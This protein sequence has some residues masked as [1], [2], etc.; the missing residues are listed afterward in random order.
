M[1]PF[2]LLAPLIG[3]AIDRFRFGHRW[4]AV[5]L[6]VLRA[7]CAAALAFALLDLALYF[8]ALALLVSAKAS[9][10]VRQA[11][12]PAL[13]DEPDQLVGANS[14]LARLTVIAGGVGG[15]VGAARAGR[16]RIAGRHARP[17]LRH[18]RLAPRSPR[19][20]SPRSTRPTSSIASVE[21]EELH[22]PTIVNTAW[23]FTLVRAVVGFFVFGLAF[24]LRRESEPAWMYGAAVAAYGVG[25]FGG[26]AIAPVLRR[27][28]GEDRLTAGS[29]V[30][31]AIVAAFGALGASRP[32]VLLVSVVL[33]GAASVGRQGFD[34][35]VQTRAPGA[36]HGRAFARFETRFQLGWVAGAIAAVAV[37]IPTR[38]SLAIVAVALIPA[39]VLYVRAL[40]EAHEAHVED[41][42]DP[43]EVARRR[44]EHALEWHRRD[45]HRLA[46]T[47][48][49]GVVDLARAIGRRA[50][51]AVDRP[52]RRA[53]G[54]RPCRRGRSTPARSTG[55][56]SGP[57]P[58]SSCSSAGDADGSGV[59]GRRR[60]VP[61]SHRCRRRRSTTPVADPQAS[62]D[63]TT[64][65]DVDRPLRR[66]PADR[67]HHAWTSR[68][69]SGRPRRR[70]RRRRRRPARGPARRRR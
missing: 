24:A 8:F 38:F 2:A 27:R 18:V 10:V 53:A 12:V 45:L 42:F 13:V 56:W 21:Y 25:T 11:L 68:P 14:R 33:G 32:L 61:P 34:A 17:G 55:R 15:A 5:F 70:P 28:Y 49:A 54:R 44:I 1:A 63:G 66:A 50:R 51:R 47:E 22:T 4:I 6:F 41:P 64:D 29:L 46:V 59:D 31:L 3:P 40:R 23:A 30:A 57:S 39:A 7:V 20:A 69:P 67:E 60:P 48:L 62:P 35:L 43:I 65:V 37:A 58:S 9:G 19:C 26:N 36:S 16:D 52:A